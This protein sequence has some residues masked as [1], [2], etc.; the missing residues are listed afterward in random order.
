MQRL[1]S[2]LFVERYCDSTRM[3]SAWSGLMKDYVR[4]R[5][6]EPVLLVV[7]R[8]ALRS[9]GDQDRSRSQERVLS[10]VG[11]AGAWRASSNASILHAGEQ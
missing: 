5:S 8:D 7:R 9:G 3:R 6:Q 11:A 1:P 4:S 2:A 10:G